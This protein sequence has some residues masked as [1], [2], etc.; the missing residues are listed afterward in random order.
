FFFFFE[1]EDGI[2]DG[3]VTGVQTCALPI[4]PRQIFPYPLSL[5]WKRQPLGF[6]PAKILA[7]IAR[8]ALPDPPL[9]ARQIG[10]LP[11]LLR[12]TDNCRRYS[13]T[14]SARSHR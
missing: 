9:L 2:R 12:R 4:S 11:G 1:A 7:S 10:A 8:A 3:H 6:A 14:G 13:S 5:G